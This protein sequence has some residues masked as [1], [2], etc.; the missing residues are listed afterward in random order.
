MKGKTSLISWVVTF[1]GAGCCFVYSL[2]YKDVLTIAGWGA[3]TAAIYSLM[4]HESTRL[5]SDNVNK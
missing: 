4:R 3:A 1:I 2:I 5:K